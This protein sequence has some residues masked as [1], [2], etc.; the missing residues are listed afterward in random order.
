MEQLSLSLSTEEIE[1]LETLYNQY[2]REF[3]IES[4]RVQIVNLFH[5]QNRL[6][7][8]TENK[9]LIEFCKKLNIIN[10][11]SLTQIA[12][13]ASTPDC[14]YQAYH[15]D[16]EGESQTIFI[17]LVDITDENGTEYIHFFD[18]KDY[19]KYFDFFNKISYNY[20]TNQSLKERLEKE[21]GLILNKHY[22][23]KIVNAKR[24]D[25]LFM[26]HY[27]FHRGKK[28]ET[29]SIRPMYNIAFFRDVARMGVDFYVP[30][31]ELDE[32]P[33]I[34]KILDNRKRF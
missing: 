28:N 12:L 26:P 19:I 34:D 11:Y 5:S 8:E 30:D 15:L 32:T 21:F 6:L 10:G 9:T 2:K 16:Y 14:E 7:P 33:M 17:P 3:N 4:K 31:A 13:I 23:F 25:V 24:Y 29:K 20:I 18:K 1:M 22:C 27:C